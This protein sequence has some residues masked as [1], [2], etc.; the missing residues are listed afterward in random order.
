MSVECAAMNQLMTQ[1]SE[2]RLHSAE[3]QELEQTAVELIITALKLTPGLERRDSLA[4]IGS[5]R[6]RIAAMKRAELARGSML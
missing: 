4:V 3:L 1:E 2:L 6:M 5:F